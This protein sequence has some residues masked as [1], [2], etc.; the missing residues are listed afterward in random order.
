MVSNNDT[1]GIVIR[2]EKMK[3]VLVLATLLFGSAENP[4]TNRKVDIRNAFIILFFQWIQITLPR[5]LVF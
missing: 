5:W 3:P 4:L 1:Y 2:G